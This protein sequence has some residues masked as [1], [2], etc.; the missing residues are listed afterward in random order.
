MFRRIRRVTLTLHRWVALAVS[1]LVILIAGSGAILVFES[2]IDRVLSPGLS[3][4]AP[5]GQA[6]PL[7]AIKDTVARAY[8]KLRVLN[9]F[10][11][12]DPA[13]SI[14]VMMSD[15]TR[16][17]VDPYTG[18]I[19]GARHNT[20]S[21]MYQVHQ[22]HTRLLVPVK[23]VRP[24]PNLPARLTR[25]GNE[26]VGWGTVVVLFLTL[27]GLLVWFP[28]MTLTAAR[29]SRWMRFNLDLHNLTGIYAVVFA[30]ILAVTG[31]AIGFE[32]P[33]RFVRNLTGTPAPAP[34]VMVRPEKGRAMIS[35]DAALAAAA[36]S[37]PGAAP[38]FVV[39]PAPPAFTYFVL[40]RFPEDATPGGR[41]KVSV[42]PYTGQVVE[43]VTSRD[44]LLGT[45]I[46]NAMRPWHTGDI[47][48]WPS[49]IVMFLASLAIVAQA[50]T[51]AIAW[52]ART[53]RRA[54]A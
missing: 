26:I 16:V 19:L 49:R 31:I 33:G 21:L 43:R 50:L 42:N 25:L 12:T 27:S 22:L 40:L 39:L 36:A 14:S 8:P 45:R 41:T 35:V 20:A 32:A 54:A 51:G 37:V 48:G 30:V 18:T 29:G 10:L 46:L 3:Y 15:G 6:V 11:P 38:A 47:Y 52:W 13:F 23:V 24:A 44:A 53:F 1:V 7:A 28:R 34:P 2:E 5:R 4:V 9:L 17:F